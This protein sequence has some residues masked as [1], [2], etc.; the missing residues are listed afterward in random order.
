MDVLD[1]E[2]VTPDIKASGSCVYELV[3]SVPNN[4]KNHSMAYLEFVP[5]AS[6]DLHHHPKG[7]EESYY[8]IEGR[9]AVRVG[10]DVHQL[11]NGQAIAIP[12]ETVHNLTNVGEGV[13]K[14]ITVSSPPWSHALH[15][16]D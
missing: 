13:L 16:S 2:R 12:P 7:C 1:K 14:F 8:I 3:G 5:G 9:A 4:A 15:I 10:D 6:C 11:I